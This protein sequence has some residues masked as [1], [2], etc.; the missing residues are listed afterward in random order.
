MTKKKKVLVILIFP[1]TIALH[2]QS[3]STL[4][5]QL[6]NMVESCYSMFEDIDDDGKVD[7]NE[8]IDDSGNGYLKISGSW[9]ACGCNCI[10]TAGAYKTSSGNYIFITKQEWGCSWVNS[11]SS[12]KE[13]GALFP[14]EI[15]SKGFFNDEIEE[16]EGYASFYV[17]IEIPRYGTDTKATIKV[18][19]F[20]LT[21][22][23]NSFVSYE[24]SEEGCEARKSLY[25]IGVLAR[26]IQDV[27][28]L[29]YILN[30][31][32]S[33]IC[34]SD[35]DAIDKLIGDDYSKYNSMEEL[36]YYLKRLFKTYTLYN[37][38]E[39]ETIILGWD[40]EEATFYVKHKQGKP[41]IQ[42]FREFLINN[43][44]WSPVC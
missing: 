30:S 28:T 43:A 7:Y 42:T 36:E 29:D 32:Y 18:I 11:V 39:S 13:L 40:R 9:P 5:E 15:V 35:K 33:K 21:V 23:S 10:N 19:P 26:N 41:V 4:S 6:W 38:I 44:Y 8:L 17:D 2:S 37:K 31:Q 34:E 3:G 14:K 1:L 22:K 27:R 24:Y 25:E 20:G 12:S 16:S